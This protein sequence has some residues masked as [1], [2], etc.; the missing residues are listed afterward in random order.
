MERRSSLTQHLTFLNE[1]TDP[2]ENNTSCDII[3]FDF[4]KAFDSVFYNKFIIVFQNFKINSLIYL[5]SKIQK[6]P[7]KK[8]V[9]SHG[10]VISGAFQGS[11]LGSFFF[12]DFIRRIV[13][14]DDANYLCR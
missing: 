14:V 4:A 10:P 11:V 6:T 1:F 2:Y 5:P 12:E 3:Y 8:S 13:A 7:V 9:S